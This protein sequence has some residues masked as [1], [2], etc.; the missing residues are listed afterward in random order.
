MADNS[1]TRF[2][3]RVDNYVKY[4]PGYPEAI[5]AYLHTVHH[6]T[7]GSIIADIG[8]GT[9]ISARLFLDK[10]YTVMT[11]EPNTAMR[12]KCIELLGQYQ[13]FKTSSGTAEHTMLEAGSVDAVLC[14]QAFHWFNNADTKA[15]FKRILKTGG[16]VILVWNERLALSGFEKEYDTLIVRNG[17]D[18]V[19]VDHRNIDEHAIQAFCSPA[20][21]SLE[22]F[23][24][25]QVFDFEGLKGRLLSSSYMPAETDEGYNK[26]IKELKQLFNRYQQDGMV[27]INY[28]TKVYVA[29]F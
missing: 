3:N 17:K 8:A 12:E 27:Q 26:L 23:S 11:V 10:G 24:N 14:A 1:T 4:R 20:K 22:I 2:S 13:N 9:G 5:V 25:R 19:S 6:L 29:N 28:A 16:I 7:I 21:V 15:E 18:Y